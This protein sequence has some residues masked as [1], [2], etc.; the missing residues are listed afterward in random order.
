MTRDF[1]KDEYP[2]Q[3]A[4]KSLQENLMASQFYQVDYE[5]HGNTQDA[6]NYREDLSEAQGQIKTLAGL[7]KNSDALTVAQVDELRKGL[8]SYQ[9]AAATSIAAARPSA[10]APTAHSRP[11]SPASHGPPSTVRTCSTRSSTR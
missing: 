3:M 2:V 11:T 4:L 9:E 7:T 10:A 5:T 6:V 8:E 1:V